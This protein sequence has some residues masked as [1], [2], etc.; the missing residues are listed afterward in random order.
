MP[1]A[2]CQSASKAVGSGQQVRTKAKEKGKGVKKE[3]DPP[4]PQS[5]LAIERASSR[6][7][8]RAAAGFVAEKAIGR[9]NAR[10]V[11][12]SRSHRQLLLLHW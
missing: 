3:S 11:D 1:V 12:L 5:F 6:G 10:N 8:W 7:S 2:A 4:T 9:L